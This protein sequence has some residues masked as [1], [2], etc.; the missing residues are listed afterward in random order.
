[1]K[2]IMIISYVY[3][4]VVG[5]CV[6]SFINVVVYRVPLHISVAKGRSFCPSCHHSL[7]ALDLIPV[8][9]YLLLR[10]KCRYCQAA[11][12]VRY[13]F[14]ELI[15]GLL[16]V[17]CFHHYGFDWMT[18]LSFVIFMILLSIALIDFDT[19]TI[20]N[21]LLLFLLPLAIVIAVLNPQIDWISRSIGFFIV[22]LPMYLLDYIIPD[23][24]GGGDIKMMAVCGIMLGWINTLVAMFIGIMT[25]GIA[26]S[27]L[28]LQKKADRKM[29]IAFG[30]YLAFGVGAALLYGDP[31]LRSYLTL[32]GL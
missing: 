4:F 21:G 8:F 16:A 17:L 3:L 7:K 26:A 13:P 30:P 29:H 24:F 1:M 14:V 27:V 2:G 6:A 25:C 20:P 19:M 23:C 10:G 9:S 22:S 15:G 28:L 18:I 31:L 5:V 32:F 11:I 12:S